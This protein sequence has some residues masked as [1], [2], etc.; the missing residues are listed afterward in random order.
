M[1]RRAALLLLTLCACGKERPDP[2]IG[3]LT[4]PVHITVR[5]IDAPMEKDCQGTTWE[6]VKCAF[7]RAD[8]VGCTYVEVGEAAEKPELTKS[9]D[10]RRCSVM[11]DTR[12][13]VLTHVIGK[14]ATI[15]LDSTGRRAVVELSDAAHVLY[16]R[17][18]EIAVQRKL[19][20]FAPPPSP[21]SPPSVASIFG[22][23]GPPSP[24]GGAGLGTLGG[25]GSIG[26]T[27]VPGVIDWNRVP[28]FLS[29]MDEQLLLTVPEDEL[30]SLIAESP[31]GKAQLKTALLSLAHSADL[32]SEG[33]VRAVSKLDDI[34]RNE[35]RD[36]LVSEISGGANNA[37][38]WFQAHPE[39]Q[40]ADYIEALAEAA[41][42]ETFDL[43][44][45]LPPLLK[46]DATRAETI[47]CEHLQ[48]RWHEYGSA[49]YE[50]DYYPPNTAALAV[51]VTRKTKCPWIVPLLMR[52]PCGEELR[53]D[54]DL[55]DDTPTPLCTDAE[56]AK[57]LHRALNPTPEVELTEDEEARLQN[58]WGALLLAAARHQGP[59]P[60]ELLRADERR[61]Y[62][63]LYTFKGREEDDA[64]R[65]VSP[66]PVDWACKLP[67]SINTAQYEG[68]T[69]VID[70]AKKTMTLSA[71]ELDTSE[72]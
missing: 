68:C 63:R 54:L 16:L 32:T 12:R 21:G 43:A 65:N 11:S 22:S 10:V 6:Q 13:K 50:Y 53:C 45:V 47:A 64:C 69:I 71:P 15:T 2:R 30:D 46:L 44:D 4:T 67:A 48:R 60:A 52:T 34:D 42:S 38:E 29:V 20:D 18:G 70:D 7:R 62:K 19:W 37:L 57:A 35:I 14:K 5:V 36:E 3:E 66:A 41:E 25:I 61:L 39:E 27:G 1:I 28:P 58:D 40:K 26:G 9:P 8:R 59:L 49:P 31:T 51:L 24:F 56:T 72:E 23:A 55:E 33:W 17:N